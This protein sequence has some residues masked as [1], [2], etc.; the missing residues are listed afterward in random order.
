MKMW[1]ARGGGERERE[2]GRRRESGA[3]RM[4]VDRRGLFLFIIYLFFWL[5]LWYME[6]L[7]PGI[8]PAP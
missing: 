2:G 5:C 7:R 4:P 6:V 8:E 1:M 3:L